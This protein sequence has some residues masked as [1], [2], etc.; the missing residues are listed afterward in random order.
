VK[1]REYS[2]EWLCYLAARG[3]DGFLV[4]SGSGLEGS[5]DGGVWAASLQGQPL[6]GE[7]AAATGAAAEVAPAEVALDM[8]LAMGVSSNLSNCLYID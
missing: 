4:E 3:H 8:A 5:H 1:N 2:Q 6:Q 7:E